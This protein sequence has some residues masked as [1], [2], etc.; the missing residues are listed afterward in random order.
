MAKKLNAEELEKLQQLMTQF[1]TTTA[2]LGNLSAQFLAIQS[3]MLDANTERYTI[4][5]KLDEYGEEL[6]SKYGQVNIDL[7][8]GTLSDP[9]K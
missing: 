9:E 7:N 4:K 6:T 2:H 5:N 3:Q 1:N 8:D